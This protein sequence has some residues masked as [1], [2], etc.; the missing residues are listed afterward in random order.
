MGEMENRARRASV[1]KLRT[2]RGRASPEITSILDVIEA[3]LFDAE[4]GSPEL[5]ELVI[6][7][8]LEGAF[9]AEL[10]EPIESYL[11][12]IRLI[13]ALQ[14]ITLTRLPFRQIGEMTGFR[15]FSDLSRA[16]LRRYNSS[17]TELRRNSG[18]KEERGEDA[19]L[20][21]VAKDRFLINVALKLA[22]RLAKSPAESEICLREGLFH[23]GHRSLFDFLV[24]ECRKVGRYD[25][26]LA[27]E[28]ARLPI[29]FAEGSAHLLGPGAANLRV[30]GHAWLGNAQRLAGDFPGAEKSFNTARVILDRD[31]RDPST[32]T[33]LDWLVGSLRL[34]Q[35]RYEEARKLLSGAIEDAEGLGIVSLEVKARFQR[36][37]VEF[38]SGG[39][40]KAVSDQE[41][42]VELLTP[43]T[44][45][46]RRHLIGGLQNLAWLRLENDDIEMARMELKRAE[47]LFAKIEEDL[48]LYH[49]HVWLLGL[50]AKAEHDIKTAERFF[51]RSR[52]GFLE[53]RDI[54]E[55]AIV[56]LDL[57]ILC[58]EQHRPAEVIRLL[59][60]DVL[61]VF[62][63]LQLG[64]EGLAAQALL[65]RAVTER[66]V[67]DEIL[68]KV[69]DTLRLTPRLPSCF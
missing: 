56:A 46:N 17:P 36:A 18:D 13:G 44:K 6:G 68:Q 49:Q 43:W 27:V 29:A 59:S 23:F 16:C 48:P 52:R 15:E 31:S 62:E 65:G 51:R 11:L 66:S 5:A 1:A 55:G 9:V 25:R 50:M 19:Q 38:F 28:I 35:R 2:D 10:G 60:E 39:L 34:F 37:A 14:L 64:D 8:G 61:P 47:E 26:R 32:K 3:N 57:A 7:R 54:H 40:D 63:L 21:Q 24:K 58:V 20:S 69:R 33:E 4:F 42:A 67:T 53:L 41:K 22:P 12:S 30:S 45:E